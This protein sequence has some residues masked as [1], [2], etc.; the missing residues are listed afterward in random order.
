MCTQARLGPIL[1]SPHKQR[2]HGIEIQVAC[3]KHRVLIVQGNRGEAPL[4]QMPGP[5]R[6]RVHETGVLPVS[7]AKGAGEAVLG[8][9][10][11]DEVNVVRHQAIRPARHRSLLAALSQQIAIER[12]VAALEDDRRAAVAP[13]GHVVR[14]GGATKRARC[15]M[16]PEDSVRGI[17]S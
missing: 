9:R 11:Q 16:Q 7:L 12:V 14:E 10:Y 6:P 8:R 13:L 4:E 5:A 17:R 2:L 1:R 3:G 15:D